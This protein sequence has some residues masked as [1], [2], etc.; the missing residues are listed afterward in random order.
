[1]DNTTRPPVGVPSHPQFVARD[2]N[3]IHRAVNEQKLPFKLTELFEQAK[4]AQAVA[5]PK[6][7]PDRHPNRDFFVADVL[8]WESIRNCGVHAAACSTSILA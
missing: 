1:M 3:T 4:T 6:V 2:I 5:P 7:T 8:E